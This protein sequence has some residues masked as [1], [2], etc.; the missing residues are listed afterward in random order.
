MKKIFFAGNPFGFGGPRQVNRNLL[1]HFDDRVA[2]LHHSHKILYFIEM[3]FKIT[4][5][6]HP[7]KH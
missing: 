3:M 6:S 7:L 4:K 1:K 2:F 5:V